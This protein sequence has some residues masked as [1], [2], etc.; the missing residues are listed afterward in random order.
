MYYTITLKDNMENK[1]FHFDYHYENYKDAEELVRA[2]TEDCESINYQNDYGTWRYEYVIEE[3]FESEDEYEGY[4][5]YWE[6][7][8]MRSD[9]S[10][11][12]PS[13]TTGDY[14]PSCPWNAPGMSVKDF[15]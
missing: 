10:N 4:V 2:L 8:E 11:Y 1:E 12:C 7:M 9:E 6:R 13:S 5:E 3:N 14:S 15:I